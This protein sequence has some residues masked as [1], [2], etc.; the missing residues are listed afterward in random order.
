LHYL[1]TG[2]R[3][4][5]EHELVIPK[6]ICDFPLEQ[7]VNTSI[8]IATELY[9]EADELL[10]AVISQWEKLQNASHGALREGFLQRPGKLSERN[11]E[12]LIQ[13]EKSSID[14]LLNYL[15]WSLSLIMLPWRRE[16][17]RVE[18]Y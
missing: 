13:V 12:D 17:L 15:P 10:D 4:A 6:V 11:Q 1:A 9:K 16:L 14:I 8:E 3:E 18:W 5:E 2:K 7:A